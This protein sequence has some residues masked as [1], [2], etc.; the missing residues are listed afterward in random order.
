SRKIAT[1][2][3]DVRVADC[4]GNSTRTKEPD[5]R[6]ARKSLARLIRTMLH[7]Q[8]LLNRS[9]Q[10]LQRLKLRRKHD[11]TRTRVDRQAFIVFVRNVRQ[12]LLEPL[13]SLRRHVWTAPAVQ[14][15][16]I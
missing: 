13:A 6:N 8:P 9:N 2:A 3:E 16:R 5:P 10:R 11:Q 12:Q 7:N 15:K 1:R 14:G 4:R